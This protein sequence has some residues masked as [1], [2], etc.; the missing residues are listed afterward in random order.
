MSLCPF[1]KNTPGQSSK[2]TPAKQR[3]YYF[4]SRGTFRDFFSNSNNLPFQRIM[5]MCMAYF[6]WANS[7][8]ID[9]NI[10]FY[11]HVPFFSGCRNAPFKIHI[12]IL[13]RTRATDDQRGLM[14]KVLKAFSTLA[15]NV[16]ISYAFVLWTDI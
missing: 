5:K 2:K 7:L 10:N 3:W 6:K 16:V 1:D 11:I 4:T 13:Q 15:N 12:I 14:T 9:K 8:Q